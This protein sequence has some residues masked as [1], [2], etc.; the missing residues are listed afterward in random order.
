MFSRSS[1]IH[2]HVLEDIPTTGVSPHRSSGV[3]PCLAISDFICSKL[4]QGLSILVTA[5]IIGTQADF[6]WLIDSTVCGITLSSAA[7]TITAIFVSFAH[8]ALK[9]VNNSCHGVSIKAIFFQL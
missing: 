8:L 7:I 2:C 6:A 4:F 5:I 1:G 9:L 3:N